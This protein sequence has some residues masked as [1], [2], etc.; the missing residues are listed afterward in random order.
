MSETSPFA[1]KT[2][3]SHLARYLTRQEQHTQ[4]QLWEA[5]EHISA[6]PFLVDDPAHIAHAGVEGVQHRFSTQN[7][8]GLKEPESKA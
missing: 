3:H 4:R 2:V 5:L 1:I 6:G 8:S 7:V